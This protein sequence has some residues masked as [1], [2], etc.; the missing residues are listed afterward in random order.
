MQGVM[1][2]WV[3]DTDSK[4]LLFETNSN[5]SRYKVLFGTL[6]STL[7]DEDLTCDG[8]ETRWAGAG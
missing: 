4:I 2:E 6:L 7:E 5:N 1:I 8:H 3:K